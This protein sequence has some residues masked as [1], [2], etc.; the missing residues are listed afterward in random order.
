[1]FSATAYVPG[2]QGGVD[3]ASYIDLD[4]SIGP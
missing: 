2:R 4:I 1:M 3:V